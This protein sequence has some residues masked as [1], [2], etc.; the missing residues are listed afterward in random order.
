MQPVPQK[1][2]PAPLTKAEL[3][4]ARKMLTLAK[5]QLVLKQPFFASLVLQRPLI[6]TEQVPTAGADAR[7]RIYVNPRFLLDKSVGTVERMMFL[8]GHET[9]HIAFEHCHKETMGSRDPGACNIAMD[10]VINELLVAEKCGE[11]IEGGERHQGAEN[12]K[13]QDLY[14]DP[15]EGDGGGDGPG[16]IGS[17]LVP[18]PDGDPQ[19]SEAE[20][21]RAQLKAEVAAAAAAAKR[22]GKLSANLA[23]L[24]DEMLYVRTPWHEILERFM[25][26]FVQTD[27][28][29]KRP[30][31]RFVG[32]GVYLPSLDRQPRMGRVGIIGDTSGSIGQREVDVFQAHVNR[33]IETCLPEEVVLLSVDAHVCNVQ[34]F[35][36][37]D[38]PI[39]WDPAGGGGTDMREGWLWFEQTGEEYD[40]IVCLTDCYTPWPESVCA[41]SIVLSTTG[42]VAPDHVGETV[43]FEI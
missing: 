38:F 27:Y 19:G 9:L 23:R 24:V 3:D 11:F 33:I 37:E 30:N 42:Q 26:S 22:Q 43:R 40:C 25:V 5:A 16:G 39:K 31:R 4:K 7:G 2:P 10:K 13:W 1:A 8:L 36:P 15:P 14:V 28:S 17:D 6:E 12:M 18:C 35:Q 29:W 20:E 32:Q 21:V 41:P 34:R